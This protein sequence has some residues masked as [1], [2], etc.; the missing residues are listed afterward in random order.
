[1]PLSKAVSGSISTT[2]T[3]AA[4][5]RVY[6]ANSGAAKVPAPRW[7][8]PFVAIDFVVDPALA[9]KLWLRLKADGN[10]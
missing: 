10:Y 5:L 7:P 3:A 8:T 1:M 2:T 9:Y 6:D 4:G